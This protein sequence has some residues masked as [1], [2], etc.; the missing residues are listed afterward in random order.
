MHPIVSE[1]HHATEIAS[2]LLSHLTRFNEAHAGPL[3]AR[4]VAFAVRD[5]D[6]RLI[7]GL[8]GEIFW[9]ALYVH[10]LWVHENHRQQGYG[11][12]LLANAE[13]LARRHSCDVSYLSTFDFQAPGFYI[14]NGYS[15]IGE[16]RN[17]PPGWKRQWFS[18]RLTT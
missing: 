12:R 11:S 4:Q 2:E 8:V 3:R 16:L 15:L 6:A 14:K 5:G 13:I 7:A 1:D 18:K 10:Q 9:N 17:V